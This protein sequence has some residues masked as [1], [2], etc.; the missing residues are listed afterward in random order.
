[1]AG[2]RKHT[3]SGIGLRAVMFSLILGSL[4]GILKLFQGAGT[5]ATQVFVVVAKR[6]LYCG[7]TENPVAHRYLV[8]RDGF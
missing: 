8:R 6:G 4:Y 5:N 1:M 2:S 7:L 3:D